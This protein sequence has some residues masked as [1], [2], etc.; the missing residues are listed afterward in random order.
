[1]EGVSM[2]FKPILGLTAFFGLVLGLAYLLIPKQM[3]TWFGSEA[4]DLAIYMTRL[5]GAAFIGFGVIAM[6]A[7]NIQEAA[8]KKAITLGFFTALFIGTVLLLWGQFT[9][10]FNMFGWLA[11]VVCG[12]L[13]LCHALLIFKK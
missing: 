10:I 9:G 8:A 6:T 13:A 7:R 5:F 12:F 11:T 1:M 3:L 4:G 2:K